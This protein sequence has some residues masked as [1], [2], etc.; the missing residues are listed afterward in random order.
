MS[1]TRGDKDGPTDSAFNLGIIA[2][3]KG[4]TLMDNYFDEESEPQKYQWWREGFEAATSDKY[5]N[6]AGQRL[7]DKEIYE[8]DA[9]LVE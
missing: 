8:K 2:A 6:D 5:M 3:K 1:S 4:K 7:C 9:H